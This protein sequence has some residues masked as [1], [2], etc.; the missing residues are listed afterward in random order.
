MKII[1]PEHEGFIRLNENY[2]NTM[3]IAI[4]NVVIECP[5]CD[6]EVLIDGVFNFDPEGFG[7]PAGDN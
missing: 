6:E 5:V 2:F 4:S 7:T 1:C 3:N